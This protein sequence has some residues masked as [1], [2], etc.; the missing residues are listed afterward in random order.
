M[1]PSAFKEQYDQIRKEEGENVFV[2]DEEDGE[3]ENE[4]TDGAATAAGDVEVMEQLSHTK[5]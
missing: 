2:E 1:Q 4:D 5:L 3:N